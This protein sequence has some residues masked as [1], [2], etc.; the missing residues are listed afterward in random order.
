MPSWKKVAVSGSSPEFN[1]ITASGNI[2]ASGTIIGDDLQLGN[3]G[4]IRS[5]T[6]T[7]I[8]INDTAGSALN[9]INFKVTNSTFSNHI[10]AS[11]NISSSGDILADNYR[12]EGKTLATLHSEIKH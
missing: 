8:Q 9:E 11:G 2:S 10:T 3:T 12:I 6:D 7:K 1:H 5:L 4:K